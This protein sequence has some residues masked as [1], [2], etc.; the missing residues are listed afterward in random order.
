MGVETVLGPGEV[1]GEDVQEAGVGEAY[2]GHDDAAGVDGVGIGF[3]GD[4]AGVGPEEGVP[5][6]D[7]QAFAPAVEA[8]VGPVGVQVVGFGEVGVDEVGGVLRPVAGAVVPGFGDFLE[9]DEV[10][11]LVL[12]GLGDGRELAQLVV[13]LPRVEVEGQYAQV[14][15]AGAVVEAAGVVPEDAGASGADF[16]G[17]LEGGGVADGQ[18][19]GV[20]GDAGAVG[21]ARGGGAGVEPVVAA[22]DGA[23][24]AGGLPG[25]GGPVDQDFGGGQVGAHGHGDGQRPGALGQRGGR[26][27]DLRGRAGKELDAGVGGGVVV[28]AEAGVPPGAAGVVEA[29]GKADVAGQGG[30]AGEEHGVVGAPEFAAVGEVGGV[31]GGELVPVA[32]LAGPV[33]GDGLA[34][35]HA[36]DGQREGQ[37]LHRRRAGPSDG[38]AYPE[39]VER[40]VVH[41]RRRVGG[42][43]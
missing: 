11:A 5:G 21:V 28:L 43:G 10:D 16:G 41:V 17:V 1:G 26:V 38:V 6:E 2:L 13:L 15:A 14:A 42:C 18:A 22:E 3:V 7:G 8:D 33:D 9:A 32:V 31:A 36:V 19:R 23:G 20:D 39:E 37:F 4:V 35:A 30:A 29:R 40:E 34:E 25:V 27:E 12:D 24:K